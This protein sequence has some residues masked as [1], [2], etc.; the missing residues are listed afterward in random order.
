MG[1]AL[2]LAPADITQANNPLAYNAQTAGYTHLGGNM[3]QNA[4]ATSAGTLAMINTPFNARGMN[5][6]CLKTGGGRRKSKK[7]KKS[8]K[9]G[10]R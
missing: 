10:R 2:Q 5:P 4:I 6:D 8:K 1:G 3:Q 7:A 9:A